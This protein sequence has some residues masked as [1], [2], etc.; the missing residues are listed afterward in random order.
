MSIPDIVVKRSW[1]SNKATV[2]DFTM[3]GF[4][5]FC[6]EDTV[7]QDGIKIYGRSAIPKGQYQV[8][9]NDS[10]RFKRPMPLLLGVPGFDGV[11][12]HSGN[13]D[14]DTEGCLLLGVYFDPKI[15]DFIGQ[16]HLAFESFFPKLEALLKTKQVFLS[17]A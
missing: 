13:T 3:G 1:F 8:I 16:S 6:L 10:Q 17:V 5:C 14:A 2:S 11:R 9:I 15:I 12:I 4:S 7:R